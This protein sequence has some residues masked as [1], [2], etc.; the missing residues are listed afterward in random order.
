MPAPAPG[1]D[2]STARTIERWDVPRLGLVVGLEGDSPVELE[3]LSFNSALGWAR[4]R[5]GEFVRLGCPA[6]DPERILFDLL[7]DMQRQAR[8]AAGGDGDDD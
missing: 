8:A 4:L 3:I 2:L 7:P 1:P 6:R 5:D